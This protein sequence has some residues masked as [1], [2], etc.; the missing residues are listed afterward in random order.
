[1]HGP[2]YIMDGPVVHALASPAVTQSTTYF[3]IRQ[4]TDPPSPP[5]LSSR[6][7][8]VFLCTL[9]YS[10]RQTD[11]APSRHPSIQRSISRHESEPLGVVVDTDVPIDCRAIRCCCPLSGPAL[12]YA[13]RAASCRSRNTAATAD[14]YMQT[15][16]DAMTKLAAT[17]PS[18]SSI[19]LCVWLCSRSTVADGRFCAEDSIGVDVF[20]RSS[21]VVLRSRLTPSRIAACRR[22]CVALTTR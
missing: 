10:Y 14:E 19:H 22:L 15:M 21:L 11:I 9:S 16:S 18:S 8:H 4:H 12:L 3:A 7:F 6:P 17:L 13:A 2:I 5:F 1:M 20:R